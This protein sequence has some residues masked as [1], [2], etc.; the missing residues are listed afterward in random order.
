MRV[1]RRYE[2]FVAELAGKFPHEAA[3]IRRFYDECWRVFNALN[4]LGGGVGG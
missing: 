3:G 4:S 2:D 1:W